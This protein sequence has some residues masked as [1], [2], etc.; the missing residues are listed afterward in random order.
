MPYMEGQTIHGW[1]REEEDKRAY[2]MQHLYR[3]SGRSNPEHPYHGLYTGLWHEFCLGE[4]GKAQRD[5]WFEKMQAINDYIEEHEAKQ[6]CGY[7]VIMPRQ[8][9]VTESNAREFIPGYDD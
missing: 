3:C 6:S 5:Q 4:A 8:L 2:F 7:E 1:D 9:E